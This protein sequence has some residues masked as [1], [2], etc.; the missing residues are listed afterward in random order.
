MTRRRGHYEGSIYQLP[1]GRW[2]AAISLGKDADGKRLRPRKIRKTKRD[3]QDALMKLQREHASGARIESRGMTVAGFLEDWVENTVRPARR[4]N[5]YV[6]YEK[7]CRLHIIPRIGHLRLADLRPSNVQAL[8]AELERSRVGART[9]SYVH[10]VL[11]TALRRALKWGYIASNPCDAVDRP[12][13]ERRK[14]RTWTTEQARAFLAAAEQ[15]RLHAMYVLAIVTGLRQGELFGL[16]W[17]DF[18]PDLSSVFVQRAL[19]QSAGKVYDDEVKTP[20]GRR[21][22]DLPP[23]AIAALRRHRERMR[24]DG[25]GDVARVFCNRLG[26]PLRISNL[27]RRDFVPLIERAGVP[28]V[29]FHEMRHTC[30]T[31]LLAA[32][33]HP[34]VVQ[35]RLGHSRIAVTL[36]TYSHVL[37]SMQHAASIK[38]QALLGE[39]MVRQTGKRRR[40]QAGNDRAAGP[41]KQV[42]IRPARS[43]ARTEK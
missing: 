27:Y 6:S 24:A 36:D 4:E 39:P 23:V 8:Y 33:E 5:T 26:G 18:D 13:A 29:T 2:C 9:R 38:M 42:R 25:L 3:A 11:K 20:A 43:R 17:S 37:P 14:M 32:G 40:K 34:K 22:I 10:A 7:T 28:R 31:L 21:R 35:E 19:V 16:H 41:K 15:D 1:D 30:A 12:R